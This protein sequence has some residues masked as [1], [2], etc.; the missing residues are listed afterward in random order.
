MA[1]LGKMTPLGYDTGAGRA[2]IVLVH[3]WW[4]LNQGMK[5]IADEFARNGYRAIAVDLYA[6]SYTHLTLPTKRIV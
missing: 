2:G 5:E 6:V 4:G 1:H 3:E